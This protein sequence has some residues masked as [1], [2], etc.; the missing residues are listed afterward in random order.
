MGSL[1]Y[2]LE[3]QISHIPTF[4]CAGGLAGEEGSEDRV[5]PCSSLSCD[6]E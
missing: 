2:S 5:A 3:V 4:L 1:S 6:L